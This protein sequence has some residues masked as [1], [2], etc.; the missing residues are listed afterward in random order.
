MTSKT[1]ADSQ[2]E[3]LVTTV[4]TGATA[5]VH[6]TSFN[7]QDIAGHWLRSDRDHETELARRQAALQRWRG[8][9]PEAAAR[10]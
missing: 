10:L 8:L 3:A 1:F 5:V 2:E 9:N 7:W 4:S 6:G